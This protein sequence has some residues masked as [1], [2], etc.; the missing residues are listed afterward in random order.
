MKLKEFF[1]KLA[2]RY[3]LFHLLAMVLFVIVLCI[4]VKYGLNIYTHHGE[5]TKLPDLT[6]VDFKR[7]HTCR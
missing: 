4:G 2:S 3:L 6:G 7:S 1:G 5:G